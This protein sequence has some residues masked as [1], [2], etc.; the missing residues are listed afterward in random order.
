MRRTHPK[1]L[2]V[3]DSSAVRGHASRLGQGPGT[4]PECVNLEAFVADLEDGS[5]DRKERL[6][7]GFADP[8]R[9]ARGAQGARQ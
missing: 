4:I 9:G 6:G 1:R 2:V 5:P 3:P 7:D 8:R